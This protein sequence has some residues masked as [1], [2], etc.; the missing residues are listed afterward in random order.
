MVLARV[1]APD[2]EDFILV[3]FANGDMVG[4]TGKLAAAV[5][6]IETVDSCV[7]QIV[8]AVLARGGVA[9]VTADHGN[10]EQEYDPET[11]CPHT[12]HT[13]YDV[14]CILVDPRLQ[15]AASGSPEVPSSAL[16]R[17]GRL[18]DVMPTLLGMM[19]LAKP[20]A[21]TGQSLVR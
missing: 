7:G 17:D 16:R 11:K 20:E 21:M 9:I 4:H 6:A 13:T 1:N 3:N 15:A 8:A 5:K 18:A 19:G 12:A 10:A 14:E 2:V